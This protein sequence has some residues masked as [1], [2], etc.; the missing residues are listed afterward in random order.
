MG[1]DF[2]PKSANQ[3]KRLETRRN[4]KH[5]KWV[6]PIKVSQSQ[7]K[8]LN[9]LKPK[10]PPVIFCLNVRRITV[11]N[12]YYLIHKYNCALTPHC[13]SSFLMKNSLMYRVLIEYKK[14]SSQ[15][16]YYIDPCQSKS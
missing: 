11:W 3:R 13:S 12:S 2:P 14:P 6:S 8:L 7:V 15:K 10:I 1:K 4:S 16:N 9:I 5:I